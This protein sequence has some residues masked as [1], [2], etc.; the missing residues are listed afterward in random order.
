ME[1]ITFYSLLIVPASEELLEDQN[2]KIT[3]TTSGF[4]QEGTSNMLTE[5]YNDATKFH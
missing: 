1:A 3:W 5:C 2:E 4:C